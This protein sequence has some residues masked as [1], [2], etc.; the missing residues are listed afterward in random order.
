MI[1]KL[2]NN[3][4]FNQ[5]VDKNL[6]NVLKRKLYTNGYIFYGPEGVGKKQSAFR[7][8]ADILN[9]YSS[10]LN[11]K[12]KII[13]NNHPDFLYIEP[14]YSMK[15]NIVQKAS[16]DSN[17]KNN[18][19]VIKIEQIRNIKNFLSKKSI[20]SGKKIVLVSDA[21]LLNEAAS[22]CL[23]KTLE[24]PSNG[25]FMLVTSKLSSLID[26]IISRCQLVRFK[27]YSSI[28]I[29]NFLEKNLDSSLIETY[30]NL[31]FQDLVNSANG[32]PKKVID[33]IRI[34]NQ[35]PLEIAN[36]LDSPLE[37]S[38]EIFRVCK[39]ISEQLEINHQI[40][41]ISFIQNIWWKKTNNKNIIKKLEE[42]KIHI[43]NFVQPRLAWE[44]KL[45][46][47][48]INDL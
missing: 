29:K 39:L 23:L 32:S 7:F 10:D 8:A 40:V 48:A 18:R 21:H 30:K 19:E 42:L 26:T 5:Q 3:Y 43:K 1:N 20:E 2:N 27:P 38:I 44:V 9:Q 28:Q 17:K 11:I 33:N 13:K 35:L 46:E 4:L 47:I 16:L 36:R 6:E 12:E 22:N 25:I 24:E 45:L 31:N 34:W 15:N 41:L 37:N 14:T